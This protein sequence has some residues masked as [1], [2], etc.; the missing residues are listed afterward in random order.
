MDYID[1][2]A[3]RNACRSIRRSKRGHSNGDT[4]LRLTLKHVHTHIHDTQAYYYVEIL[5]L[6]IGGHDYPRVELVFGIV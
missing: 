5:N 6:M 2:F 4:F 3:E 1:Q